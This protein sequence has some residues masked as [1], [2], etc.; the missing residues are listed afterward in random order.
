MGIMADYY[1]FRQFAVNVRG[2]RFVI[3]GKPGVWS[4]NELNPGTAAL[5]EMPQITPGAKT[6]DLGCGTGVIGAVAAA[7]APQGRVT[8]VD[9]NVAAVACARRTLEANGLTNAAVRLADGVQDLPPASF[10]MVLSHL[11]RG[12]EVQ[13][14]LIQGAAWVL[15]PGGCFYFVAHKQ[16]GIKG[17]VKYAREIFGRCGV[18]R[19]KKGHH[20]GMTVK[21]DEM[22]LSPPKE[23][24]IARTITLDGVETKLISKPGVFA[25]GRLDD[26]TAALVDAME[27]GPDDRVLDLGCGTGLAGLVAARRAV[28]GEIVLVD[29]DVRA[30]ESSRRTLAVNGVANAEVLP[31]DCASAVLEREPFDVIITNPPFHQGLGVDDEVARQFVRDAARVIRPGGRLF[32]VANLFL[33]Y[34]DLIREAFGEVETA[35]ADARYHVLTARKLGIVGRVVSW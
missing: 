34:G 23:G 30:V 32:L 13:Q 35:F 14:L 3:A 4:W 27:I 20:V 28:D 33:R 16:A 15:K 29:V 24:Y 19:Q 21:P 17:A 10:D 25:W 31:L 6:L 8:L 9:C 22:A 5:L 2:R 7:S 1:T 12:R 26:G 18:V 11:P